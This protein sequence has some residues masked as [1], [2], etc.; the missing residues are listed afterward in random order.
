ME[1]GSIHRTHINGKCGM[2]DVMTMVSWLYVSHRCSHKLSSKT[3]AGYHILT[4]MGI[5]PI[6]DNSKGMRVQK[7]TSTPMLRSVSTA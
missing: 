2:Y 4:G 5:R 3:F 6:E 7:H 1:A